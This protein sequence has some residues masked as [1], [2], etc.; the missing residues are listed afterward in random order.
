MR[1]LNVA[2]PFAPVHE[3]TAGG[4]EQIVRLLDR[5][6]VDHGDESIVIACD[7]S[8]VAGE[9]VPMPAP[10]PEID[11]A[12]R[13]RVWQLC[14]D[15]IARAGADLV[16]YHGVDFPSY[17]VEGPSL[18]TLHL[19]RDH[20]PPRLPIRCVT[21]SDIHNGIEID[22]YT[23]R[24]H[25]DDFVLTLGRI[26]PEKGFHV[27]LDAAR[28]AGVPMILAGE[29]MPYRAHREYFDREIVPR[30]DA[31]RQFIGPIGG[32]RKRD[33]LSRVRCVVIAS[34]IAETSSL[35]AMESL[36]SGTPVVA[37]RAGALPR[38]VEDGVTGFIVDGDFA[39][40][41][42]HADEISPRACRTAAETR[43]DARRMTREYLDLYVILRRADAEGT[44]R[45]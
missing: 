22:T 44:V 43:F 8:E 2:Y 34:T 11:D 21:P 3:S 6:L 40:A 7:G 31:Q 37:S 29:V 27:A 18:A 25:K 15:A 9:L 39:D 12:W 10:P 24:D 41:I 19:P 23:F 4:A 42:R 38:I 20:Y 16:H 32:A 26:C 30:L 17:Y 14:R 35:V 33:L 28:A 45:K 13:A 5:A 36:A 1:I